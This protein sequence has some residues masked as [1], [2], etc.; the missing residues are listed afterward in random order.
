M[1]QGDIDGKKEQRLEYYPYGKTYVSDGDK[2]TNYKYTGKEEDSSTGPILLRRQ[3]LHDSEI[4][5]F[6][7]PGYNSSQPVYPQT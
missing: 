6:I 4:G 2:T 1:I 5:R 7:Q 3:I